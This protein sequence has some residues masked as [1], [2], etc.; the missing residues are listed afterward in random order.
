[1]KRD[2]APEAVLQEIEEVEEELKQENLRQPPAP[3]QTFEPAS[4]G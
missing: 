4:H 1:L 2:V 3:D